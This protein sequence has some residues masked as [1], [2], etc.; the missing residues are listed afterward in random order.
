[1]SIYLYLFL[2]IC[3]GFATA[4]I[5]NGLVDLITKDPTLH[6]ILI[7]LF[8]GITIAF[9]PIVIGGSIIAALI[10]M[11]YVVLSTK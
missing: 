1:M 10:F 9:W 11:L 2:G 3:I 4:L 8:I 5:W 6:N 7:I